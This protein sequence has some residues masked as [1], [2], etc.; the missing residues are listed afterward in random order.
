MDELKDNSSVSAIYVDPIRFKQV[1]IN[2]LSNAIKYN[3]EGGK[4]DILCTCDDVDVI[5]IAISDSGEG[6]PPL[7]QEQ[8][9]QP[10]NRL[11]RE[12]GPIEGTGIGLAITKDLVERM[13]GKIYFES[14][15]GMGTTFWVEFPR[16]ELGN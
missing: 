10:F 4:I 1:L 14:I 8:I 9:F 15:P 5:R 12:A 11:G 16:S 2:L 7:A 13:N 3:R 6:I